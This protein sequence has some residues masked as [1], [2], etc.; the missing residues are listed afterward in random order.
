MYLTRSC[1]Y[2]GS[3]P[4]ILTNSRASPAALEAWDLPYLLETLGADKVVHFYPRNMPNRE[5]KPYKV[6][7]GEAVDFL[8]NPTSAFYNA[9]CLAQW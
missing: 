8:L 4:F 5:A 1:D 6:P 7:F 2:A 3:E 9:V